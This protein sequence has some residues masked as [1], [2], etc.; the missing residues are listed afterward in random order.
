MPLSR[1]E[2]QRI[3]TL[4]RIALTDDELDRTA[5]QLGAV[6]E[7]FERLRAIDTAGV[8]PMTHPHDQTLRLREDVADETDRRQAGQAMAP[9]V[10][11]GLYLVPKVIE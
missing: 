8:E 2:V 11:R 4:A 5:A 9:A 1:D 6:L 7:L 3:A 10:E